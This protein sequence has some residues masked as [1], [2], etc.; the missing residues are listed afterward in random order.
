MLSHND[1][2]NTQITVKHAKVLEQIRHPVCK[3]SY[4]CHAQDSR[5]RCALQGCVAHVQRHH[6]DRDD[7]AV[8]E[9]VLA[10]FIGVVVVFLF[11]DGEV[12]AGLD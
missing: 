3:V 6:V 8:P 4:F 9:D 10:D 7:V 5:C 12:N 2:E 1:V 11:G